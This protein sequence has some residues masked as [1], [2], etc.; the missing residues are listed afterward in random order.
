[1]RAWST[2]VSVD[3]TNR[4]VLVKQRVEIEAEGSE[5]P[6]CVAEALALLIPG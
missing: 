2:P 6:V 5:R 4:G 3:V 1:V